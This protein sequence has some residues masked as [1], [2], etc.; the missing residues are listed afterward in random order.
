MSFNPSRPGQDN[1]SGDARALFLKVATPEV[2]QQFL[3][4]TVF[5]SK[6]RIRTI[7]SGKSAQHIVSGTGTADYH[8][9]GATLVGTPIGWSEKVISVDDELVADRFIASVDEA[10]A[11]YDI[12]GVHTR[13]MGDALAQK[14]DQAVARCIS[15]AARSAATITGGNGGGEVEDAQFLTSGDDLVAGIFEAAEIFDEKNVPEDER[16]VAVL[17]EQY[18]NLILAAKVT[19]QDYT[20]GTN[21]GVNTGRIVKVAGLQVVKTNNV[22]RTAVATGPAAYQGDFTNVAGLCWHPSAVGTTMLQD[23]SMSVD[24]I[25]QNRG[26][27][28]QAAYLLGHGTLR[29]EAAIELVLS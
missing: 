11:H 27:L 22:P 3:K 4:K 2:L 20:E 23:M 16:Y 26:Y 24:W 28:M 9:P 15:L 8:T 12:R 29:P 5:R 17:P 19:N 6:T 21:G 13:E 14:F 10:I 1:L 18:Y 7:S 25:A